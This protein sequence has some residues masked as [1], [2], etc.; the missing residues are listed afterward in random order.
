MAANPRMAPIQSPWKVRS[1]ECAKGVRKC[2]K[3]LTIETCA[4]AATTSPPSNIRRE[5]LRLKYMIT[6]NTGW[7][8]ISLKRGRAINTSSIQKRRL[9]S[10]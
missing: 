2:M 8:R 7:M 1:R 3:V 4:I 9:S 5:R 10:N 6:S